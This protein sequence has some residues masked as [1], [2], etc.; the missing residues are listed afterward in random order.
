MARVSK[1]VGD[2]KGEI[3]SYGCERLAKVEY[4]NGKFCCEE[5]HGR[6]PAIRK[7]NSDGTKRSHTN[8]RKPYSYNQSS[9]WAKGHTKETHDSLKR[10][11]ERMKENWKLKE[12]LTEVE[13]RRYYRSQC[14]WNSSDLNKEIEKI[15][16]YELLKAHGMYNK[17]SNPSGVVRDHRLSIWDGF[18]MNVDPSLMRHPANCRFLLHKNNARKSL[19]SE[20][21]LDELMSKI[22]EWN[23]ASVVKVVNTLA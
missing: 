12:R 13:Q 6:C 17:H 22:V 4:A 18:K 8:G 5:D 19:K 16:G 20:I 23:N 1:I 2:A 11:S 14:S 9:N 21:T 3:C 15:E 10:C 7:K